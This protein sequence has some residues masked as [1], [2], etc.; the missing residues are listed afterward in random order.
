MTDPIDRR[1]RTP[2][3]RIH[4]LNPIT[5]EFREKL[6][7]ARERTWRGSFAV[8]IDNPPHVQAAFALAFGYDPTRFLV[9]YNPQKLLPDDRGSVRHTA[10]AYQQIDVSR[11][12]DADATPLE[13]IKRWM[14]SVFTPR[15][16]TNAMLSAYIDFDGPSG[17]PLP[18]IGPG[19]AIKLMH[20][21]ER[22]FEHK[23]A[24]IPMDTDFATIEKRILAQIDDPRVRV[25][26]LDMD[27]AGGDIMGPGFSFADRPRNRQAELYALAAA[28][29]DKPVATAA[30]KRDMGY[31]KHDPTKRHK[32]RKRK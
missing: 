23:M 18:M 16:F 27:Q 5:D 29:E 13:D 19:D 20:P 15:D 30:G 3:G 9:G 6:S 31:L 26:M 24:V 14:D 8:K 21:R 28:F 11:W 1:F 22:T 12:N 32:R 4:W 10:Y 2:T 17:L 7:E 25:I